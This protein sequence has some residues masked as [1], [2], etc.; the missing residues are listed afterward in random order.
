MTVVA[1]AP[2]EWDVIVVGAGS[3]GLAAALYTGRAR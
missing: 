1:I 2:T 3:A